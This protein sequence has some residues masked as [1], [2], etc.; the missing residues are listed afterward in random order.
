MENER[1]AEG[2][3]ADLLGKRAISVEELHRFTG[4]SIGA[5]AGA[6]VLARECRQRENREWINGCF[7]VHLQDL[8]QGPRGKT[9]SRSLI[10][11]EIATA[12]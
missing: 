6:L 7:D 8:S 12:P 3:L 9:Q 2:I 5:C 4:A 10:K 1:R 11:L